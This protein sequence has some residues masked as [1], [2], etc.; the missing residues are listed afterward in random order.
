MYLGVA[1][2]G[3]SLNTMLSDF[4]HPRCHGWD[5]I[6]WSD[7]WLWCFF[8]TFINFSPC[9]IRNLSSITIP[10]SPQDPKWTTPWYLSLTFL[11]QSTPLN[12]S[13]YFMLTDTLETQR[14]TDLNCGPLPEL[15]PLQFAWEWFTINSFSAFPGLVRHEIPYH[16]KKTQLFTPTTVYSVISVPQL[17]TSITSC[18]LFTSVNSLHAPFSFFYLNRTLII[19]N[20]L[21]S[22]QRQD[23]FFTIYKCWPRNGLFQPVIHSNFTGKHLTL[24]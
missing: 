20:S 12:F 1:A 22:W 2:V 4:K 15:N 3:Q 5:A 8:N 23:A 19:Y 21:N 10:P 9:C 17:L 24:P 6:A 13:S 18:T 16:H 7:R 14:S 11:T